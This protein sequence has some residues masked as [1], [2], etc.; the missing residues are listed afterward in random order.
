[1]IE[2]L[3]FCACV[4]EDLALSEYGGLQLL[5]I[6][7]TPQFDLTILNQAHSPSCYEYPKQVI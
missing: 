5:P 7:I 2:R 3:C 4:S 1:M 6:R